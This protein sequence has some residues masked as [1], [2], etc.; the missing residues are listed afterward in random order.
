MFA[1]KSPFLSCGFRVTPKTLHF[2]GVPVYQI[3]AER[4]HSA[5]LAEN[6]LDHLRVLRNDGE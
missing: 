2:Y 6:A 1:L 3:N 4:E 5:C